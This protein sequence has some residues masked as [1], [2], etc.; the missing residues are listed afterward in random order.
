MRGAPRTL[1]RKVLALLAVLLVACGA[2]YLYAGRLPG[3]TIAITHPDRLV[4]VVT[5]VDLSV[6]SPGGTL[7]SLHLFFDQGGKATELASLAAGDTAALAHDGPDTLK[8]SKVISRDTVPGLAS[9]P[10]Q[11]RV[12]ATRP[13]L[14]GLRQA[15]VVVQKALQVRLERPSLSVISTHHYINVGGAEMVV[16][17]V[18]PT[19]VASGVSVGDR[20]YP[21]FPAAGA[22]V[23]DI[24]LTDPGLRVAFFAL[25]LDDR[26]LD[27]VVPAIEAGSPE[28]KASGSLITQFLV[29]NG[30]LRRKNAAT[31]AA[32]ASRTSPEMLWRG[33]TFYRY[34][35]TKTESAFADQRTYL[36][37]GRVVDHQ[38]HLGFD[39]ASFA[40]TP[41]K[42]ANRGKVLY[43]ADLGIYGNCVIIDHGMGVQSLYAHLSSIEVPVG[44][45]VDKA[46]ELGTSGE[47]GMAG[48]DHL[49]FTMLVNGQMVNPIEWWD[50]HWIQD[51]IIRKRSEA[52]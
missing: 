39:L 3:P 21:G 45:M 48:G 27:R 4:G 38:T 10:A 20:E 23:G 15:S 2:A 18:T 24:H 46:Q 33:D 32:F 36:Y 37:Q 31:I 40:H 25:L 42:A 8:I 50:P 1:M 14:F 44:S 47:T 13:V 5:P 12:E 51:R 49:H 22:T 35:N 34:A 7:T 28:V 26:Y 6:T 11:I 9:G 30:D 43:A 19:D 52:R 17:R 16:Y 29:L 41:V